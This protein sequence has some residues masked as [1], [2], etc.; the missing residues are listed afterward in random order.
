[1]LSFECDPRGPATP[2]CIDALIVVLAP[3][4]GRFLASQSSPLYWYAR[5]GRPSPVMSIRFCHVTYVLPPSGLN[6]LGS[7]C[8]RAIGGAPVRFQGSWMSALRWYW[9]LLLVVAAP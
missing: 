6:A 5:S 4:A 9:S 1:M 7:R 8:V 2:R 3:P